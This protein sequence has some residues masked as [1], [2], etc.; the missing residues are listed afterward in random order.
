MPGAEVGGLLAS[1]LCSVLWTDVYALTPED[2]PQMK[3]W[4]REIQ[5]ATCSTQRTYY[6]PDSKCRVYVSAR[7]VDTN[8]VPLADWKIVGEGVCAPPDP[9]PPPAQPD[10]PC[11]RKDPP[12]ACQDYGP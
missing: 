12:K 11:E 2:M 4:R 10:N 7:L 1:L 3:G 8:D 9:A 5:V 6:Q